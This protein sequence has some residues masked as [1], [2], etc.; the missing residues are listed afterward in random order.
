MGQR[1][2]STHFFI[3]PHFLNRADEL[4]GVVALR[5]IKLQRLRRR[6]GLIVH[7]WLRSSRVVY[8]HFFASGVISRKEFVTESG[9]P[10]LRES[11]G[12]YKVGTTGRT[13]RSAAP[14]AE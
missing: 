10:L 3:P 11:K 13:L 5:T 8:T 7:G 12:V 6:G 9:V 14:N 4:Y 2:R 1:H